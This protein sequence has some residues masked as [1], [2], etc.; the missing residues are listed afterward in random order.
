MI[1]ELNKKLTEKLRRDL[2][3]MEHR[4]A[5]LT[6]SY[7]PIQKA[8]SLYNEYDLE[9]YK[10]EVESD[11]L[12]AIPYWKTMQLQDATTYDAILFEYSD[13]EL[14]P[15]ESFSFGL[16]NMR[17]YKLTIEPH[18]YEYAEFG[19]W[20]VGYGVSLDPFAVCAPFHVEAVEEEDVYDK[21]HYE[22]ENS[23]VKELNLW[24]DAAVKKILNEVFAAADAQGLFDD[25]Q[26]RKGGAFMYNVHDVGS[27][28]D[29]FYLK[30]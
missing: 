18:Y 7:Q 3:E 10:R 19:E 13:Q 27:V 25:L 21:M 4:V 30:Q 29:P 24:A 2:I 20:N 12:R 22:D 8:L 11:L 23:G 6:S 17:D 28:Q 5:G 14:P 9:T 16:Y 15:F 1:S 26:L